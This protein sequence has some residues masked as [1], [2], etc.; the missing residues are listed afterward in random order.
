MSIDELPVAPSQTDSVTDFDLNAFAFVAALQTFRTQANSTADEVQNNADITAALALGMAL[1]N[2]GGT[3]VTSLLIG[4]GAKSFVTQSGKSWVAGQIVV[5]SNGANYM[6]G[7]VTSYAS[8]T[9]VVNVT[10]IVG[11]GTFASW[12]I[13]LSYDSL[14]LAPRAARIDVASVAGVVNLTTSAPDTDDIQFTGNN[15]MT[16]FTAA[17]GR[18]FR[19]VVAA[20]ATPSFVNGGNLITHKGTNIQLADGDSGFLRVLTGGAVEVFGF[21]PALVAPTVQVPVRQTT[22]SAATSFIAIGTGLA[23]NLLATAIP[24]RFSFAAGI[25]AAGAVDYVGS[26]SAD[27]TGFWSGLTA[28]TTNYLFVD[29]NS[30]TGALTGVASLLPY[31]AQDSGV[32]ISV[33]NGQHTYVYDTG[34]MYVGNGSVATAVQRTSVGECVAGASTISSVTSYAKLGR[35]DSGFTATLPAVSTQTSRNSNLGVVPAS[36]R[37]LIECTT[38]DNGYAVGDLVFASGTSGNNGPIAY[39]ATRTTIGFST[40]NTNAFVTFPKTGGGTGI[41]LTNANWKYKMTADRGW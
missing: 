14:G 25:G 31:I 34:Q 32:A 21:V 9:L 23:C 40:G 11:S 26:A 1:P 5:A 10:R 41:G 13:G 35:Y 22:L 4:T 7:T 30:G 12:T 33:V 36:V 17:V 19:F 15:A 3:S 16:G 29:R 37:L 18:V 24:A 27:V 38:P 8:T 6:K 39:T 20:G 28:N 2:Y